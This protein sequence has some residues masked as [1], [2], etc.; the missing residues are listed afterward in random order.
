MSFTIYHSSIPF[1]NVCPILWPVR[2]FCN[3]KTTR[4]FW[5]LFTGTHCFSSFW[6]W[7]L[8][9][10]RQGNFAVG[11]H[12]MCVRKYVCFYVCAAK[13]HECSSSWRES[14]S[15]IKVGMV[16]KYEALG[17]DCFCCLQVKGHPISLAGW[18][19]TSDLLYLRGNM[20]ASSLDLC[21][22]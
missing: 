13:Y 7:C 10:C 16:V 22:M 20:F 2:M 5:I 4:Y 19:Y 9:E 3:I 21:D 14:A 17:W 15:W 12:C 1:A 6:F 18:M 11:I 8:A